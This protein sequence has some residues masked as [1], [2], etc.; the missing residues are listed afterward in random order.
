MRGIRGKRVLVTGAAGGIGAAVVARLVEEGAQVVAADIRPPVAGGLAATMALD[1]TEEAA[2]AESVRATVDQLGGLD[3]LVAA[4]GIQRSAATHEMTLADFRQVLDVSVVGTFLSVKAVLPHMLAQG[5]GRIVT[6]GS[7]AA[8]C[9]A[10]GLSAYAAAK[11]AVLQLTR[12]V[13]VEYARS[14]VRANCLCPGGTMTP[15]M[16]EIDRRRD[17]VDEFRERHPIGRYADP[18]EVAAAATFL[19]SDE[20]SFVLGAAFLVDG[21]YASA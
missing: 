18:A 12:S 11:G 14:G 21:G 20:S 17:G 3:A 7:T 2:V 13:A 4:A 6:F 9:A 10:P 5:D 8:V 15:M 19:L 16:A 1:V